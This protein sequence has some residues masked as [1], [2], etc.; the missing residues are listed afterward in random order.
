ML[1]ASL[2]SNKFEI[3]QLQREELV[4]KSKVVGRCFLVSAEGIHTAFT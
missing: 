3:I 2:S 1:I 4:A